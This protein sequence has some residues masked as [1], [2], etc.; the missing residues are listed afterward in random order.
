VLAGHVQA[1]T[2]LGIYPLK[3]AYMLSAVELYDTLTCSLVKRKIKAIRS[4]AEFGDTH[5]NCD[6]SPVVMGWRKTLK[7]AFKQDMDDESFPDFT[8]SQKER[9]AQQRV[10]ASQ[11]P[12]GNRF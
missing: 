2:E 4:S 7:D 12:T 8:P 1:L 9:I 10:Q 3:R 11:S 6:I 5:S